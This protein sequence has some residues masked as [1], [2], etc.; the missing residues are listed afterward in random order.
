MP[1]ETTDRA[2]L[3]L[4]GIEPGTG[5]I[6]PPGK[7]I[8][9]ADPP[10]LGSYR[11][12]MKVQLRSIA[13]GVGI[14]YEQLTGDLEGV[15]YSSIRAGLLEFRRR[16]EQYQY[17]SMAFQ[18]LRPI[19]IRWVQAAVL[20]GAIRSPKN[21]EM[22]A[23][24]R[25]EFA[26]KVQSDFADDPYEFGLVRWVTPGWPWVDPLKDVTASVMEIRSGLAS[27][28]TKVSEKGE[29][30]E[31]IDRDQ[32]ADNKRVDELGLSYDSDGRRPETQRAAD[33]RGGVGEAHQRELDQQQPEVIQ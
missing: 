17:Q 5:Q 7:K 25:A 13:A 10:D 18:V 33:S 9:F 21:R 11:D 27:R 2:E 30:V 16:C 32:V 4:S 12:F 26:K 15:N 22:N 23:R 1:E 20:A 3:V 28:G 14:T 8:T 29:D 19:A 31:Q 6:V 24:A